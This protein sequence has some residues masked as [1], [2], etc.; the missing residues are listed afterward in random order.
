M[1]LPAPS[2]STNPTCSIDPSGLAEDD[3]SGLQD[4]GCS[5][6]TL[7]S[8]QGVRTPPA[9]D[10]GCDSGAPFAGAAPAAAKHRSSISTS[11]SSSGDDA[12]QGRKDNGKG[13]EYGNTKAPLVD[14]RGHRRKVSNYSGEEDCGEGSPRHQRQH[15]VEGGR[16][17]L[18]GPRALLSSRRVRVLL[19]L[20]CLISVRTPGGAVTPLVASFDPSSVRVF[21][22]LSSVRNHGGKTLPEHH[23][24]LV[25]GAGTV[26][27]RFPTRC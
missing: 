7:V 4:D 9:R 18:C 14:K 27:L 13:L 23:V 22:F 1:F 11:D 20:Q 25:S 3:V 12:G 2:R 24:A 19:L 17:S 6:I 8:K 5:S 21:R 26:I 15:S 16:P 10:S